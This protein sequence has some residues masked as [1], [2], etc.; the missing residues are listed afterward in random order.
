MAFRTKRQA[1]YVKLISK[2]F[3][4]FEASALSKVPHKTPYMPTVVSARMHIYNRAKEQKWS[5]TRYENYI[6]AIYKKRGWMTLTRSGAK[7]YSPWAMLRDQEDRYADKHPEYTSP[8]LR[9]QKQ[10]R[11]FQEKMKNSQPQ[12]KTP[13]QQTKDFLEKQKKQQDDAFRQIG[14]IR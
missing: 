3:L 14:G 9:K 10:W 6:R 13:S 2:G 4:P 7:T 11:D 8:W 1:Q 5:Q 12:L